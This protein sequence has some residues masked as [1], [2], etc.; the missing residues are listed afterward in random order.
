MSTAIRCPL[1][2]FTVVVI[3]SPRRLN[4]RP[5][6]AATS[7][8]NRVPRNRVPVVPQDHQHPR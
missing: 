1:P 3:V 2:D 8:A 4:L 7:E 5:A 6:Q